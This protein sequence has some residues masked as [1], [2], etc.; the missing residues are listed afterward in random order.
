[1]NR[2]AWPVLTLLAS[3]ALVVGGSGSAAADGLAVMGPKG[4]SAAVVRE[5]SATG[6]QI[7][8][9]PVPAYTADA[10]YVDLDTVANGTVVDLLITQCGFLVE[11]SPATVKESVPRS[12]KR[13]GKP[14]FVETHR[15]DVLWTNGSGTLTLS[16]GSQNTVGGAEVQPR[17]GTDVFTATYFSGPNG[18]GT[19]VGTVVQTASALG[20]ARLLAARSTAT[21][22][23]I[24]I[25][26]Q[27]GRDFAVAQLRGS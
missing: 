27:S 22:Q 9:R 6:F 14:P 7:Y 17:V 5:V 1:M 4:V 10:C 13:W 16:F 11:L 3:A 26:S 18:T 24:V 21:W 20:G 15:P 12:W 23:S 19:V 25:T 8:D 2:N